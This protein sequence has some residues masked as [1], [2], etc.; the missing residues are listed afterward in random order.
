MIAKVFV[1][2]DSKKRVDVLQEE[3]KSHKLKVAH[4]D[5]LYIDSEQKVGIEQSRNIKEFF[6]LMPFQAKGRAIVVEDISGITPEAQNALLKLLEEPPQE[7][8]ILLGTPYIH[9]LL[10]TVLS[11]VQVVHDSE[12]AGQRVSESEDV[13][14]D[15]ILT[16]NTEERF[17]IV[18]KTTD[19]KGL[20][21]NILKYTEKRIA[22][23]P[24]FYP[25]AKDILRA[26]EWGNANVN[27]RGVLEYLMLI[28]P[29][30]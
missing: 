22:R 16:S 13:I 26:E 2:P 9:H 11:R 10:P 21:Q 5:V 8:I 17:K 23:D 25:I 1:I 30:K 29:K 14:V 4:A 27:M 19:K 28:I 3:L 20:L 24:S 6:Q 18:E 12:S 7:A 15:K